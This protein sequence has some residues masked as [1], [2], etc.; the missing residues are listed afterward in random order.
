MQRGR[1]DVKYTEMISFVLPDVRIWSG[2][3]T[4]LRKLRISSSSSLDHLTRR[5]VLMGQESLVDFWNGK[6]TEFISKL[7]LG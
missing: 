6:P 5:I 3:P 2:C 1:F 4:S 7:T